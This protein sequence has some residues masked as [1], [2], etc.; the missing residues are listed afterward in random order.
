MDILCG[1]CSNKMKVP[2]SAHIE[3]AWRRGNTEHVW[4]YEGFDPCFPHPVTECEGFKK[5]DGNF[6]KE[7]GAKAKR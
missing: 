5:G 4:F 7:T 2:G 3:C 6:L 1:H